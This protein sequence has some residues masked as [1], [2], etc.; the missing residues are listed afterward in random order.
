[1]LPK[2]CDSIIKTKKKR[3]RRLSTPVAL[4][5]ITP[6]KFIQNDY[7]LS[8]FVTNLNCKKEKKDT[9]CLAKMNDGHPI[10]LVVGFNLWNS[11]LL[12][13]DANFERFVFQLKL[14]T[15]AKKKKNKL[16]TDSFC[17]WF[18]KQKSYESFFLSGIFIIYISQIILPAR[19]SQKANRNRYVSFGKRVKKYT[20]KTNKQTKTSKYIVRIK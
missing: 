13:C 7:V 1:M 4:S 18:R 2:A 9:I 15:W 17:L 5:G 3:C 10:I 6:D 11:H 20:T 14:S 8:E 19:M 12:L 16:S